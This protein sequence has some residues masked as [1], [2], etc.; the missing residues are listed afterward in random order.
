MEDPVSASTYAIKASASS[1]EGAGS[2]F[3]YA[4]T[5]IAR[6]AS[7]SMFNGSCHA[8]GG[9]MGQRFNQRGGQSNA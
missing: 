1:A 7:K 3:T 6:S 2:A 5:V 4:G 8:A 9:V